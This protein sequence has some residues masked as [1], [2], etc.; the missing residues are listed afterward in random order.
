[1][2][3]LKAELDR[4]L[5]SERRK[6]QE[7]REA[8]LGSVKQVTPQSLSVNTNICVFCEIMWPHLHF[9]SGPNQRE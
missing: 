2:E 5:Q 4:E 1:M 6:L 9:L 3:E 7:E 8:K